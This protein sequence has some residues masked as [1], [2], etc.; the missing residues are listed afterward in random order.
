MKDCEGTRLELVTPN[1]NSSRHQ[2]FGL[3]AHLN[4]DVGALFSS[5][6][7]LLPLSNPRRGTCRGGHTSSLLTPQTRSICRARDHQGL[8]EQRER[9]RTRSCA[10]S[11]EEI[12]T[13]GR[14]YRNLESE[15]ASSRKGRAS[16]GVNECTGTERPTMSEETGEFTNGKV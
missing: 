16:E 1:S 2:F 4:P 8:R 14:T 13:T 9:K 12:L 15:S 5:S 11:I 10:S 6:L 7:F 3:N